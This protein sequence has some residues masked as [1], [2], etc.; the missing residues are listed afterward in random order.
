MT[1][2]EQKLFRLYGKMP[3]KKDLLQNKLKVSQK[4]PVSSSKP[5]HLWNPFTNYLPPTI[6]AEILRFG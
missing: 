4:S 6:G 3:N 5:P 1:P 2:E